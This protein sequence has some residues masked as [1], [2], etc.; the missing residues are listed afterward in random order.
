MHLQG[1]IDY[2]NKVSNENG[3]FTAEDI[4]KLSDSLA[5]IV[6]LQNESLL[7]IK[8]EN[9]RIENRIKYI[10]TE[11]EKSR[12]YKN[13]VDTMLQKINRSPIYA[14]IYFYRIKKNVEKL[15]NE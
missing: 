2:L 12:V 11:V 6:K 3:E 7:E 15:M 14:L 10:E 9:I 13:I 5:E 8:N 4:K 1:I